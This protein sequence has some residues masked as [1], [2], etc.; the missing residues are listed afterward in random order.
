MSDNIKERLEVVKRG[1]P[2][3]V[4][5]VPFYDRTEVIE[6]TIGTVY[7]ALTEEIII[8][9]IVDLQP[10]SSL[11]PQHISEEHYT[12]HTRALTNSDF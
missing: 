9:V 4:S 7:K 8:T 10:L 12:P 5:L 3:G 11:Y 2:K 1:L 6:R